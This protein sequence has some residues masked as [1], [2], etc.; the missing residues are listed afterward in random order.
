MKFTDLM[1]MCF[2][3]L[4]RRK[5]RTFLTVIGIII[6]TCSIILMVSL[7]IGL[8]SSFEEQIKQ[9]SDITMID[10]Y[11]SN[12]HSSPEDKDAPQYLLNEEA[13]EYI[14]GLPHVEGVS[15]I[16]MLNSENTMVRITSGKYEYSGT[17]VGMDLS[18]LEKMG[19]E[20]KKGRIATSDDVPGTVIVG[21]NVETSF[22][23]P[24]A[25]IT[26]DSYNDGSDSDK[27][28]PPPID[29]FTDPI[30]ISLVKQNGDKEPTFAIPT[31]AQS[32]RVELLNP[33]GKFKL[34]QAKD[35]N[36]NDGIF[37]D[38]AFARELQKQGAKLNK[39]KDK[40]TAYN[41]VKIKVDDY[42][43][44]GAIEKKLKDFGFDTY[45]AKESLE[46]TKSTA[47]TIQLVLGALGGISLLVAAIGITNTMIMS[48]YE[49]TREIGVMKVLGCELKNIKMLFLM[50]SGGIGFMGGVAGIII[51]YILSAIIN[52]LSVS[53]LGESG[54]DAQISQIP[55]WL[56]LFGITFSILVGVIAG[57]APANRAVKISALSAIKTD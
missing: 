5:L 16:L 13:V 38:V 45:S 36:T 30:K 7:G 35:F 39:S 34:N 14:K 55:P 33:V 6:G 46:Q 56:A 22:Y 10:V 31:S 25:E 29:I 3:N 17:I 42:K 54:F 40:F 4:F 18:E 48:I 52:M 32:S 1:S 8:N 53:F 9:Y 27:I 11:S 49:R 24:K 41:N 37:M 19:Y 28:A 47:K 2:H 43:N 15:P 20:I 23:D 50:E 21:E 12:E 44:V 57:F 51:S 26:D